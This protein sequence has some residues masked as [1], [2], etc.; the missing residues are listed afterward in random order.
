VNV[1]MPGETVWRGLTLRTAIFK[2]LWL[3]GEC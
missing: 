1:G 2:V 3:K